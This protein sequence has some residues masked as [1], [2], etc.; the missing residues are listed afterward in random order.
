M[1]NAAIFVL[2]ALLSSQV[3]PY[4]LIL[5]VTISQDTLAVGTN[6]TLVHEGVVVGS[7][8]ADVNGTASFSVPSGSYFV[9]L[10]RYPY[11]THVSLLHI[12]N[13]SSVTL[14]MSPVIS[15]ANAYGQISGPTD[16][17]NSSV[18]AYTGS[19]IAKR[20]TLEKNKLPDNAGYYVL[21]FLPEGN[22]RLV[23]DVS[24]F[25]PQELQ[26]F[27]PT[28]QY[29]EVNAKLSPIVVLPEA[30]PELSAPST[31][32]QYSALS[33][34]LSKGGLP[35]ANQSVSVQTPSGTISVTTSEAGTATINAA[36]QGSYVFS[37]GNLT[38]TS[39]VKADAA[40]APEE[41]KTTPHPTQPPVQ[42]PPQPAPDATP[43]LI[44]G[45]LAFLVVLGLAAII[46]V[47]VKYPWKPKGKQHK[48]RKE[49]G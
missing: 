16:F 18:T 45:G 38:A 12:W 41:N 36:E 39:V 24:G 34:R 33:V 3:Y 49:E 31:V 42:P 23:F 19:Q 7:A 30:Q 9:L 13:D 48:G 40:V 25:E 29:V 27:L 14:T 37:F 46:F 11:P 5:K 32:L 4:S 28:S 47:A 8:K 6:I 2:L 35:L 1:K 43:L 21:S 44:L 26:V 17:S 20:I 22:Y 15:Y 10:N